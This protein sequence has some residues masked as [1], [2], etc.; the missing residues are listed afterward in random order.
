MST[1]LPLQQPAPAKSAAYWQATRA[2]SFPASIVPVFLGTALAFRGYTTDGA[3][4]QVPNFLIVL[5]TL[6]GSVM[7]QAA[8]NVLNDYYDFAKG[9]D[10]K[11]EHGGGVLTQ[12]LLTKTEMF[13]F[14]W[15]LLFGAAVCGGLILLLAPTVFRVILPLALLGAACAVLYTPFLK[16]VA[17]GDLIIMVAFGFEIT[18]GAFAV[19]RPVGGLTQWGQLALYALPLTLLVDAILHANNMRDVSTDKAV[20]VHTMA[21]LLGESGSRAF[22][23]ILLFGPVV[24]VTTFTLLGFLPWSCLAVLLVIPVLLKAFQTGDVPF[25]A[26]SHL[27]FGLL[28][29]V[30]VAI[31]PHR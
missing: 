30:G 18:I 19:Q 10:T 24:L 3:T 26:Q 2:Y 16:Q 17:L 21:G 13:R 8:G 12:G 28:Y 27:L 22:F 11:P 25:I 6:I 14:G 1:T 23:A 31:M 15:L 20:G 5:L 7:A 29:S 4:V 9:V